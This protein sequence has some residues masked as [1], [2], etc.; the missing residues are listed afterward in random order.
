MIASERDVR[1]PR[2]FDLQIALMAFENG[3]SEIWTHDPSFTTVAG[4]RVYDP[5]AK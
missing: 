1:G 3:A 2:I 4:L 5:L